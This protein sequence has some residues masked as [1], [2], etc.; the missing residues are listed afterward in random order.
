LGFEVLGP[1]ALAAATVFLPPAALADEA[2]QAVSAAR[3]SSVDGQVQISL[4]NQIVAD[5]AVA[6]AP[7]FEGTRVAT[8]DEGRAEIQFEDG[9]VARLSPNSSLTLTRLRGRGGVGD[10]EGDSQIR[11]DA[12]LGYFEL[13]GGGQAGTIRIGF[14]DSVVTAAGFTVLRI[15]LDNP[16]GEVAVFSGNAHIERG[17]AL[18]V[19]LHGGESVALNGADPG[20]YD[21]SE[22]IEPD[23]WDTWNSDRDQMLAAEGSSR[24]AATQGFADSGNPAWNDLDANG[25]WYN[26]PGQGNIWSPYDA[27]DAGFDPY[28]NG[29]WMW[30]PRFGYVWVSGYSWGYL[31]FQCGNWNFY[32]NFGWG[33]APGMGG[34]AP[35]WGGGHYGLNIGLIPGGYRPPIRPRPRRPIDPSGPIGR[36]P[37]LA[38]NH[39][40][41]GG[42]SGMPL[43]DR[44][45]TVEIAGHT[46]QAFRPLS[47]RPQYER[48]GSGFV[49]RTV[50]ITP[51]TRT[52]TV[53]SPSYGTYGTS[54]MGSSVSS[55][56]AYGARP[57]GPSGGSSG[58]QHASTPSRPPSGGYS[59]GGSSASHSSGGGGGFSGGG[60]AAHSGG[61]GGTH[62]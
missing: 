48:S 31:P 59:G 46:V 62:R 61:G 51:G 60:G 41:S 52:G 53:A 32:D 35:W 36:H 37:I 19:D 7:L 15:N 20:H 42:I 55:P 58:S 40:P 3:L 24:T 16:P 47:P 14:G 23:S 54:R 38:V 44:R 9:S 13:R 18:V 12:G 6:N 56:Y 22:S 8:G 49:N 17:S 10:S 2:A 21:L 11:L 1:A 5:Q 27:S 45:G 57:S 30:T 33:W 28:G 26:V 4:D 34:C 29:Y 39:Q 50:V 43:R 25:N